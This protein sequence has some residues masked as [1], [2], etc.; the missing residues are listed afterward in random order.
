M[1]KNSQE[2]IDYAGLKLSKLD[3]IEAVLYLH[4]TDSQLHFFQVLPK[5]GFDLERTQM[6]ISDLYDEFEVLP[7][8][9][10]EEDIC[11]TSSDSVINFDKPLK[12]W[13]NC[14]KLQVST[15]S[16]QFQV[17]C[18]DS[19]HLGYVMPTL[20]PKLHTGA[21]FSEAYKKVLYLSSFAARYKEEP[22]GPKL[23]FPTMEYDTMLKNVLMISEG[24]GFH[25]VHHQ[26]SKFPDQS[27][28]QYTF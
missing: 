8:K 20:L 21:V 6:V 26:A 17:V 27:N 9:G 14:Y 22:E 19:C 15:N 12:R 18:G 11:F 24:N 3:S 23:S 25:V 7:E 1:F 16:A 10:E 28:F 5:G 4:E 2:F 13:N